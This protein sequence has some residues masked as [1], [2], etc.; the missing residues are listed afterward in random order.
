M[1]EKPKE[2]SLLDLI[3]VKSLIESGG[4]IVGMVSV[5]GELIDVKRGT[6]IGDVSVIGIT[7][8]SITFSDGHT[9]KTRRVK[10]Y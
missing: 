1:A 9:T 6:K 4:E 7:A 8:E 10:S 5:G 2:P 3:V